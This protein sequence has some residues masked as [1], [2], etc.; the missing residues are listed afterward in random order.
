MNKREFK[1]DM[2]ALIKEL[3]TNIGDD[4]RATDDPE[5]T[6]PGMQLTVGA[7]SNNWGYQTGDNSDSG[8]A[9]FYANWATVSIYRRSNSHHLALEIIDQLLD[10]EADVFGE[11]T[12]DANP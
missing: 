12:D 6:V 4:Y 1:R 5:D 7:D 11:S 9:Y 3:K 2:V 8:A 10:C